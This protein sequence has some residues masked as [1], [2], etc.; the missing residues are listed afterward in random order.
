MQYTQ[1]TSQTDLSTQV[2]TT[3]SKDKW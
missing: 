1:V 2:V 3:C